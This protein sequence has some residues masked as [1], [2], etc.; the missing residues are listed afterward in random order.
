M[1]NKKF[2]IASYEYLIK[3][4][5]N[6]MRKIIFFNQYFS[7][8]TGII[9]RHDVD[10]SPAMA[11]KIAKIESHKSVF[12]TFFV[13]LNSK[14]YN[15]QQS[16]NVKIIKSIISLGHEVG[17]HFDPSLYEKEKFSLDFY[18]KSECETLEDLIDKK[19]DII[20]FHRP[21][22]KFIG[23]KKK[24][25]GRYH[26]YMPGL[27][28]NSKYCSDSEGEWRFDD[29][30]ELINNKTI[31]NIQL[32]THPIWWTT[33]SNMSPGEKIAFFLKGRDEIVKKYA[34]EN[35]KPY[36]FYMKL[37]KNNINN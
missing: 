37:N 8:K 31:K 22:K 35:C 13:M 23:M 24:I 30:E 18:C 28:L 19:I 29:P 36:K 9:L 12:S 7:G 26:S 32:L 14:L 4:I 25:A 33:P 20:S 3:I 27:I 11:F 16:K 34:A 10:F 21:A 5:K 15:M 1:R 17:L 2:D 6:S